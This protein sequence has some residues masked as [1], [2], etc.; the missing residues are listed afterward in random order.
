VKRDWDVIRDVLIEVE[1]LD[2]ASRGQL[3]FDEA[4]G[5]DDVRIA[6]G[7][8]LWKGQFIEGIE[9]SSMAGTCVMTPDLTWA[10][11]DLLDTLRSKPVWDRVKATAKEKGLELTFET[12]KALAKIALDYVIKQGGTTP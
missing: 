12:V 9:A 2:F 11:H 3:S 5:P 8:L 7:I 6:M 4:E 1:S 10:G